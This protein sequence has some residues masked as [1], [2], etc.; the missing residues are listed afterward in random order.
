MTLSTLFGVSVIEEASE[1]NCERVTVCSK[2]KNGSY[3]RSE[4]DAVDE[5]EHRKNGA[6]NGQSEF[7]ADAIGAV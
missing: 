1:L 3:G 2:T 5:G 6:G 4:S 7:V